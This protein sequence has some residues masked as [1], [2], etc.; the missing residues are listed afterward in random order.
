M[1]PFPLVLS[2]SIFALSSN[3][4]S[5]LYYL[6]ALA[7]P[8]DSWRYSSKFRRKFGN[9]WISD[10]CS[11]STIGVFSGYLFRDHLDFWKIG[12]K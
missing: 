4:S 6:T 2:A 12:I 9:S 10:F 7:E 5:M 3:G 1:S 8:L 11:D